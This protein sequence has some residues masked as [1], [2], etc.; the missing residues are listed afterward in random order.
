MSTTTYPDLDALLATIPDD[1]H[2]WLDPDASDERVVFARFAH[3]GYV[4]D[5]HSDTHV[6][7]L[8]DLARAI[9]RGTARVEPTKSQLALR[10]GDRA[11]HLYVYAP[12]PSDGAT[13]TR[14]APT[15]TGR[16]CCN[17]RQ[18]GVECYVCGG[19]LA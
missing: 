17:V 12:L 11:D 2:G 3:G 8:R 19:E 18:G 14:V 9:A 7:R 6:A 4:W 10:T 5:C 16:V 15:P 13:P 1:A